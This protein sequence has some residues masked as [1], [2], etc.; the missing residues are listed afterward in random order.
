[1]ILKLFKIVYNMYIIN[2]TILHKIYGKRSKSQERSKET[3]ESKEVSIKLKHL[4]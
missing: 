2:K 3:K 4:I 1:M